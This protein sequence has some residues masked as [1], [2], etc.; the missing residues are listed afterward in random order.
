MHDARRFVTYNRSAF[1]KNPLQLYSSAL[2]F[3]PQMSLVKTQFLSSIP[4][5]I[6]SLPRVHEDWSALIHTLEGHHSEYWGM[7]F[8]NNNK[9][10]AS[11]TFS[12]EIRICDADTG[13]ERMILRL[14]EEPIRKLSFSPNDSSLAVSSGHRK[15]QLL[16]VASGAERFDLIGHEDIINVIRFSSNGNLLATGSN[17]KTIKLWNTNEGTIVHTFAGHQGK[18]VTINFL[19]GGALLGTTSTDTSQIK[20]W[21]VSTGTLLETRGPFD[22]VSAPVAVSSSGR[23]LLTR[24]HS[25]E[26]TISLWNTETGVKLHR[27]RG[28]EEIE[29]AEF[30]PGE[31]ML[32]TGSFAI[33]KLWNVVSGGLER[34]FEGHKSWISQLLVSPNGRMLASASNDQSIKLWDLALALR[35]EEDAQ[36]HS[37]WVNCIAFSPD[38]SLVATASH[39]HTLQLWNAKTSESKRLL[40]SHDKWI[41]D[42]VISP[43][44]HLLAAAGDQSVKLWD[45]DNYQDKI[46]LEGRDDWMTNVIFSYDS[47]LL[48]SVSI[49]RKVYIWDVATGTLRFTTQGNNIRLESPRSFS[50]PSIVD[51]KVTFFNASDFKV[52][53]FWIDMDGKSKHYW[54]LRPKMEVT[55]PT[56]VGH[57]WRFVNATTSQAI[58]G[59]TC[60]SEHVT[61]TF[62]NDDLA[63]LEGGRQ[64]LLD[65]VKQS[66]FWSSSSVM[67]DAEPQT[68]LQVLDDWITLTS[69]KKLVW[70]PDEYRP[71]HYRM[72]ND[73]LV[74]G[75]ASGQVT[76]LNIK[77]DVI[78]SRRKLQDY[79]PSLAKRDTTSSTIDRAQQLDLD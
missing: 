21:D 51:T 8:S 61:C 78:Q 58:G 44:N 1:E 79:F 43:T 16:D 31:E 52:H 2:L 72:K 17:D 60:G 66:G 71:T 28:R 67:T 10:L 39:N 74:L 7:C 62:T 50:A 11:A 22:E 77:V 25:D 13:I 3:T 37:S 57:F 9:L 41:S 38:S 30:S 75:H 73:I 6:G 33:I 14:K 70:L 27:W 76:F 26:T 65:V 40:R 54:T 42:I 53:C 32:V 36:G 18:V 34:T 24:P 19:R 12:G 29:C 4:R 46:T 20:V 35:P 68:A 64:Y 5:W 49:N 59:Y 63:I 69:G 15:V 56:Y 23:L 48:A 47:K 55:Q 45:L